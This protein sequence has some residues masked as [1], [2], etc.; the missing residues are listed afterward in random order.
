MPDGFSMRAEHLR[1]F[2]Q[3]QRERFVAE[4]HAH[5]RTEYPAEH[6]ALGEKGATQFI[7]R[8]MQKAAKYHITLENEVARFIELLLVLGEDFDVSS[9]TPWAGPILSEPLVSG[10]DRLARIE[11][12]IMFGTPETA[13]S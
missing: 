9:K 10:R 13:R 3:Q 1:A 12:H 6:R 5:I 8:S 2:A 7:E 11:E 4:M